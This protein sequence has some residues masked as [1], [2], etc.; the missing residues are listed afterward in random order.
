MHPQFGRFSP[1]SV[2]IV[3]CSPQI[4]LLHVMLKSVRG[5]DEWLHRDSADAR[6][7][8]RGGPEIEFL[9]MSIRLH[10]RFQ[11]L[12]NRLDRPVPIRP[13]IIDG[14]RNVHQSGSRS[15]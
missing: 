14:L 15:A 7:P 8:Q 5:P 12:E 3:G 10:P 13:V 4:R 1:W 2:V 11:A 6:S 9:T